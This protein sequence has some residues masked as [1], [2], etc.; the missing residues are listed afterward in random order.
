MLDAERALGAAPTEIYSVGGGSRSALWLQIKADITGLPFVATQI[1]D[2]GA[3]GAGDAQVTPF[4]PSQDV[5]DVD[6]AAPVRRGR[7]FAIWGPAGAPGRST[8]A[9]NLAAELSRLGRSTLLVVRWAEPTTLRD[10]R[11]GGEA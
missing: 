6:A 8:L 11:R 2:A 3:L 4:V 10:L 9:V 5:G 7:V 1:P